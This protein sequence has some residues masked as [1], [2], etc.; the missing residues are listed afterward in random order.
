MQKGRY[1]TLI[2]KIDDEIV[3]QKEFA[4]DPRIILVDDCLVYLQKLA[5]YHRLKFSIRSP[6]LLGNFVLLE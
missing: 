4:T 3:D 6:F 5:E 2:K 1:I